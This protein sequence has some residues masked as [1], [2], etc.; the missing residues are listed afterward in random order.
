AKEGA[1]INER[2]GVI[3]L[4]EGAG[5][6]LQLGEHALVVA[7][8]DIEGTAQAIHRALTMPFSERQRRGQAMRAAVESEDVSVWF[9]DQLADIAA[10]ITGRKHQS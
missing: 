1:L 6:S 8:A 10:N 9:Q 7:P 2:S 5:A 4:S 3:I